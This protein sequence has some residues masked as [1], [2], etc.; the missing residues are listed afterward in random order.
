MRFILPVLVYGVFVFA[1]F[2]EFFPFFF[3]A[4]VL[5]SC[6]RCCCGCRFRGFRR[7]LGRKGS[8]GFG[9]AL[10][11]FTRQL[12]KFIFEPR[13]K[14]GRYC[15]GVVA[16]R[17]GRIDGVAEGVAVGVGGAAGYRVGL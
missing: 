1:F 16:G 12:L 9:V 6:R 10:F 4:Y 8:F 17:I 14:A 11:S 3:S 15:C 5:G 7:D 13:L 2:P